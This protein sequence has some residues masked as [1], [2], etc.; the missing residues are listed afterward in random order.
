MSSN[1][2][3]D[4]SAFPDWAALSVPTNVTVG[5]LTRGNETLIAMDKCCAPNPVHSAGDDDCSLWC[6]IP[7][8]LTGEEWSHCTAQYIHG[9]HI[10]TFRN[11]GTIMTAMR[12]TMMGVAVAALLFSGLC[13][14]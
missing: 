8:N 3:C 11:E 7:G 1:Q 12:P 6:E 4:I 10:V 2:T 5:G 14:W 13:S 9:V